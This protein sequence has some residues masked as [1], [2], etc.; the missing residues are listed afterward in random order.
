MDQRGLIEE[1]FKLVGELRADGLKSKL[2]PEPAMAPEGDEGA[3][4]SPEMPGDPS[5][6]ASGMPT[7]A[8]PAEGGELDPEVLRQ[9]LESMGGE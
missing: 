3:M 6:S 1:I 4:E 5:Q 8:V 7:D 2:S 9:L